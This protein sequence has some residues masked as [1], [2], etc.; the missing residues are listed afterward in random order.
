MDIVTYL[1]HSERKTAEHDHQ[2]YAFKSD[3]IMHSHIRN[4]SE[5]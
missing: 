1:K 3:E 5:V 4:T 2:N